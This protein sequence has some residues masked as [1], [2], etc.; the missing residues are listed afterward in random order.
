MRTLTTRSEHHMLMGGRMQERTSLRLA[1]SG[2]TTSAR[3][4]M[5]VTCVSSYSPSSPRGSANLDSQVHKK[6]DS[7]ATEMPGCHEVHRFCGGGNCDLSERIFIIFSLV[8]RPYSKSKTVTSYDLD[9]TLPSDILANFTCPSQSTEVRLGTKT[10]TL[11]LGLRGD[12][13]S[14]QAPHCDTILILPLAQA[15][16]H[17]LDSVAFVSTARESLHVPIW[18]RTN[19]QS[20]GLRKQARD[21]SHHLH[22]AI[23]LPQ[24]AKPMKNRLLE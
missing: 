5:W 19:R 2:R 24:V 3:Q 22:D 18:T 15:S 10:A 11:A 13:R 4:G 7:F 17:F 9:R 23:D 20:Q 14:I 21:R 12:R 1:M 16:V 8:A 6:R